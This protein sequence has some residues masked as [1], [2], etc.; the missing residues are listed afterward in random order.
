MGP[1]ETKTVKGIYTV[2]NGTT[3]KIGEFAVPDAT[4]YYLD[5]MAVTQPAP[6]PKPEPKKTYLTTSNPYMSKDWKTIFEKQMETDYWDKFY[7]LPGQKLIDNKAVIVKSSKDKEED[8]KDYSNMSV[9]D[10]LDEMKS[11]LMLTKQTARYF[12][13]DEWVW[14]L[15]DDIHYKL[16]ESIKEFRRYDPDA[17]ACIM[18]IPVQRDHLRLNHIKLVRKV[19]EEEKS[20]TVH[21]KIKMIEAKL[22]KIA[23]DVDAR[24]YT[25]YNGRKQTLEYVF[26][27][28]ETGYTF[29]NERGLEELLDSLCDPLA[30]G[31]YTLRRH[32]SNC[33]YAWKKRMN[34]APQFLDYTLPQI[35]D[36]KFEDPAVIVFWADGTKTVVRA[37][38]EAY[39]PE[40]GLAMAISR[41]ALGN[42]RDYYHVFLKWLKKAKKKK[43]PDKLLEQVRKDT[44][45][46][47]QDMAGIKHECDGVC[48][49]CC[50]VRTDDISKVGP[51]CKN[52]NSYMNH[53]PEKED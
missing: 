44:T 8:T 34:I 17:S 2:I 32:V 28:K 36:V 9:R 41:K 7:M 6:E 22:E 38:G 52:C 3:V 30:T 19:K 47:L 27:E 25:K 29:T 16:G 1:Q 4:R 33:F 31:I 49:L 15:S 40:K 45:E 20:M 5:E 21:E 42:K 24:V 35:K 26:V 51:G 18:G 23:E 37:Q 11:T 39:D 43:N 12:D 50:P 13:H 53:F 14:E 46:L 10:I 48:E